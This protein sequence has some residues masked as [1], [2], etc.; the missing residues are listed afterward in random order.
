[1][2]QIADQTDRGVPNGAFDLH[3]RKRDL[4]P[5]VD[6]RKS[7]FADVDRFTA[8]NTIRFAGGAI[9]VRRFSWSKPV[10]SV[11]TTE[12]RCYLLHMSLDGSGPPHVVTNLRSGSN[13]AETFGRVAL[14]PP[15]Q[16]LASSSPGG[17][18]RAMRCLL[19]AD[20]V[21]T[22][23]DDLPE[24]HD[25]LLHQAFHLAG[26]EIEWLMR[27]MY[28]EVAVA[29]FAMV[30]ALE[31]MAKQL[32]V[33]IVRKFKL[34]SPEHF[35]A[36]GLAP[37][38]L[39]RLRERLYTDAALPDLAELAELCDMTVRHLSR[40]FRT[41]TGQT[42]GKYVEAAMVERAAAML[43]AGATIR[44]VASRLGFAGAGDF[45]SAFRRATGLLPGEIKGPAR[46]RRD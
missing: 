22:F 18:S 34:R 9:E 38:R 12:Q 8:E 36:G 33:E 16:A 28:R 40:A 7:I 44:E 2:R 31:A 35:R 41:E 15:G 3:A 14:M 11:W 25:G 46:P 29:D 4:A 17:S 19:D 24:W 32:A 45:R 30:P 37:W 5:W 39:R 26:G 43:G 42:L 10:E 27:R 23:V 6:V 13:R 20:L 1:M 21:E